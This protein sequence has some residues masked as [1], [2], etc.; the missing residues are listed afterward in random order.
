[1]T[2]SLAKPVR[3]AVVILNWNG[4][5]FLEQ[6]LPSVWSGSDLIAESS[7][8]QARDAAWPVANQSGGVEIWLAD[9]ASTDKSV[10]F[11]T[12]N[13]PQVRILAIPQN[14]G[15]AGGYNYALSRI[16][17]EYFVL[18]NQDVAVEPGWLGPLLRTLDANAS[19]GAAQPKIRAEKD[20]DFFEYAGAAGGMLDALGYPFC[21]GRLFDHLEKD[22]GQYEEGCEIFWA[23]GAALFIRAEL[24]RTLGGLDEAF[25]AHMEEI[26]LCWRVRRAGYKVVYVPESTVYHVG[27]G[28][29]E[30]DNPRKL[31]LNFRNNGRMLVKNLPAGRLLWLLPL[32]LVLD[33]IAALREWL[34]GKPHMAKAAWNGAWNTAGN[35]RQWLR[36]A[37]ETNLLV[38]KCRIGPDRSRKA[39]WYRGSLV[40]QVFV[41]GR[42]SWQQLR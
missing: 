21:R 30:R 27:G 9:N 35:L 3:V 40:W 38:E 19:V 7:S 17:A 8:D 34:I 29:L 2:D 14:L 18:L 42:K 39:G 12:E 31:Y 13:F 1:M 11:V 32:R 36:N 28:S 26:D 20:R 37:R 6:F 4:L 5:R 16:E 10:S 23:S 33:G 41:L 22:T 25:F 24:Y 15:F